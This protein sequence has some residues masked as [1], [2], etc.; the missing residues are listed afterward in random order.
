MGLY[1]QQLYMNA[2]VCACTCVCVCVYVFE[3][4]GVGVLQ[5]VV[6]VWVRVCSFGY[7]IY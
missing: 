2:L 5:G 6:F 3:C 1:S 7:F 4:V